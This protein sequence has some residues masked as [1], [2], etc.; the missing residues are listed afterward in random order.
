MPLFDTVENCCAISISWKSLP[1]CVDESTNSIT[2]GSSPGGQ[3]W[4]NNFFVDYENERCLQDCP[5]S[6]G[7]PCA[8]PT[9]N[10]GHIALYATADLCCQLGLSWVDSRS[11]VAR[12]AGGNSG[13]PPASTPAQP[14]PT[15]GLYY[16]GIPNNN[17]WTCFNDAK[18]PPL[19]YG[20]PSSLMYSSLLQCC[21]AQYSASSNPMGNNYCKNGGTPPSKTAYPVDRTDQWYPAWRIGAPA[22]CFNDQDSANFQHLIP[23]DWFHLTLGEC[24]DHY[25]N[26]DSTSKAICMA[27]GVA[28]APSPTTSGSGSNKWYVQWA[29]QKCVQDCEGSLPCGGY[30]TRTDFLFDSD[31]M[32][33]EHSLS[34]IAL[35]EC[36]DRSN[37]VAPST[38][39]SPGGSSWTNNFYVDYDNEKCLQDCPV[40]Q[41]GACA[42]ETE[43]IRHLTLYTTAEMCCQLGL[44]WVSKEGCVART[45]AGY[46]PPSPLNSNG[47]GSSPGSSPTQSQAND[48]GDRWY[49]KWAQTGSIGEYTCVVD[50]E[51]QLPCGGIADP[52]IDHDYEFYISV[53]WCCRLALAWMDV[54]TC[55][56]RSYG[57]APASKSG[58]GA[59]AFT[60]NYFVDYSA[61][62]CLQDCPLDE[63]G[64]CAGQ[65]ENI[66]HKTVFNS[67]DTCCSH[68]LFW[69]DH[70]ECVQR[71]KNWGSVTQG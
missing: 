17:D 28:T 58:P 13:S 1:V 32:C 21:D 22:T 27:G 9:L 31:K 47:G 23:G 37:N 35:P 62:T 63:G 48:P 34:W 42:G 36:L 67:V 52:N 7:F 56:D 70:N 64:A 40:S 45:S 33:C 54:P 12:T 51:G 10:Y 55:I 4:S 43:D 65:T 39:D 3:L 11:C 71:S 57:I 53:E 29:S 25:F 24:C 6:D 60:R 38:V 49:V 59:Y 61:Q 50:C 14:T 5:V 20:N 69:L 68:A 66:Q 46:S 2:S 26:Y 30:A 44:S 41:G 15:V 18:A 8:G 19:M 16:A